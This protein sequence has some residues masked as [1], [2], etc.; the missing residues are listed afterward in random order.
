[1]TDNM[2]SDPAKLADPKDASSG[3][4]GNDK[5]NALVTRKDA[6]IVAQRF[7]RSSAPI[8]RTTSTPP[9]TRVSW[10]LWSSL[11]TVPPWAAPAPWWPT[12]TSSSTT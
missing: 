11:A 4:D 6:E 8:S 9:S 12:P 7:S 3:E 10:T 1:M 2:E 5:M